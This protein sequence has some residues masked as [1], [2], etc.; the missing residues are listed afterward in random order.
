L[1]EAAAGRC[2]SGYSLYC[3]IVRIVSRN[4]L[5]TPPEEKEKSW[6]GEWESWMLGGSN[7]RVLCFSFVSMGVCKKERGTYAEES[8]YV[9]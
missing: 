8:W 7:S 9:W 3:F 5:D 1:L 4:A 2:C 6:K